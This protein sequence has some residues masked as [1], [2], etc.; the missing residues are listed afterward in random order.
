MICYPCLEPQQ[1]QKDYHIQSLVIA[2]FTISEV[3][4]LM[5]A[6]SLCSPPVT[7][8][9]LL[10]NLPS[11]WQASG[12]QCMKCSYNFDQVSVDSTFTVQYSTVQYSTVQ[13][14]TVQYSTVQYSTVQYSTVQYSTVQYST[15]HPWQEKSVEKV[16][17]KWK[18]K[19]GE[20]ILP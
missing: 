5:A 19:L 13:Y 6:L 18:Q 7:P 20:Q 15:V 14:S 17:Q 4:P 10:V 2:E 16:D 9:D 8:S 1:S 3:N 12:Q 11:S